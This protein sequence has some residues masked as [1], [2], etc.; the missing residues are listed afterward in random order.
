MGTTL[1]LFNFPYF[2]I[3]ILKFEVEN[4]ASGLAVNPGSRLVDRGTLQNSVPRL[5]RADLAKSVHS[6]STLL[7]K[8]SFTFRVFLKVSRAFCIR[9]LPM[10]FR[11]QNCYT[12][13][14]VGPESMIFFKKN[15]FAR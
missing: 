10:L 9:I 1:L 6:V 3:Q 13:T 11:I 14:D 7:R 8:R 2:I 4:T 5:F 15:F 12:G